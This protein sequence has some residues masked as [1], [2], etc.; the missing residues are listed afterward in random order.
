MSCRNILM[1]MV[2]SVVIMFASHSLIAENLV[3]VGGSTGA[4]VDSSNWSPARSPAPGDTLTFNTPVEISESSFDIGAKGLNIIRNAN[5]ISRV[6]FTGSA[7]LHFSGLG[8]WR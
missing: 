1:G 5:V 3:W 4:F 2:F 7:V 8:N 6:S